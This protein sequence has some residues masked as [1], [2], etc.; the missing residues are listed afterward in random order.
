MRV[1]IKFPGRLYAAARQ[2][3]ERPHPFAAERVGFVKGRIGTLADDGRVV[4]LTRYDAIPDADYID[5]GTVG[6]KIG[7][8]A[9]IRATQAVY[10]GRS[11]REGLF[12]I[13]LHEHRGETAMSHVDARDIP[14]IVTGFQ[15]V[16]P[17]APHGI[18]ILSLDHGSGWVWLPAVKQ[19]VQVDCVS[20][21]GAPI[22]VF[23]RRRR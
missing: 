14:Q 9:I 10:H 22:G 5:D 3:L 15:A 13:H 4:L 7:P 11:A 23:E 19:P 1:E 20:V 21:I 18:I 16:G 6:A 17:H 2:D 12:H 8:E